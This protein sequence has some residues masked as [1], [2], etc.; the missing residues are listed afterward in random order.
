MTSPDLAASSLSFYLA[1]PG[2]LSNW[3]PRHPPAAQ[4]LTSIGRTCAQGNEPR[5]PCSFSSVA[6]SPALGALPMLL[7]VR[8]YCY[9]GWFG[10]SSEP[11]TS[12]PY[13]PIAPPDVPVY[14][15]ICITGLPTCIG[16]IQLYQLHPAPSFV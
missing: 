14:D 3:E 5:L 13:K 10:K 8:A 15:S 9:I 12:K 11:S 16:C 7:M 1:Y 2:S 4:I 6:S